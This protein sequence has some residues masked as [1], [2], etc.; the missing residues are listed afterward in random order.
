MRNPKTIP[1]PGQKCSSCGAK[2]NFQ[3]S[4]GCGAAGCFKCKREGKIG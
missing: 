3:C 2:A 1:A 4:C